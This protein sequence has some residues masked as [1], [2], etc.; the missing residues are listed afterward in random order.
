M[1]NRRFGFRRALVASACCSVITVAALTG[2]SG[3]VSGS[4]Q[5]ANGG[6]GA[7]LVVADVFVSDASPSLGGSTTLTA[8]VR[9]TGTADAATTTLRYYRSTDA[10]ISTSDIEVGM[11]VIAELSSGAR[12]DESVQ[13]TATPG[14][15]Y[16]G[17]CVDPVADEADDT[18]NCSDAVL[19][20]VGNAA[21]LQGRPDLLV[22]S[23]SASDGSPSAGARFTL[24]ASVRNV[25][26]G[27]STAT[28]L[29]YYQ[30][31]DAAISASDT[32]VGTADIAELS[33]SGST[34]ESAQFT[35][36]STPGAYYFGA[37]VDPV[38]DEADN[39]NNCSTS[40]RITVQEPDLVVGPPSVSNAGPAVGAKFALTATVRN[41][42]TG[43]AV[44]TTLRYYRSEDETIS[45]TDRE[46]DS[47]AVAGL[48]SSGSSSQSVDLAAPSTP[49]SY[50][51][52]A[53]VDPVADESDTTNNCSTAVSVTVQQ[54]VT[55]TQ[56]DPD[57]VVP[58]AS[59]SESAP[60]A[61]ARFRLS[62]TV[63]N[64]GNGDADATSMYFYRSTDT[65]ITDADTR[66]GTA[67]VVAL[68]T[69]GSNA[70]W[71]DLTAP[72]TP[73]TYYYGACAGAVSDETDTTN[74]CSAAVTVTVPQPPR[75]DLT[76]AQ[77]SVTDGSPATGAPFTLS[78]T[79]S[80]GGTGDSEATTLRYYRSTDATISATDTRV[81]AN[82]IAELA[83]AG[84]AGRSVD[85][86]APSTPGKY[87]YGACVDAVAGEADTTN[88][89]SPSVTV[90]ILQPDLVVV[91][92]T[93]NQSDPEAGAQFT[94]SVTVENDGE[95]DS[96]AATL[97]YYSSTDAA[98]TTSDTQ[99]GTDSVA[100]LAAAAT[101]RQSVDLTA[102]STP[103]T[104]Y[105]GACVDAVTDESDTTNNCSASVTVMVTEPE[106]QGL[107][108]EISVEDEEHYAPVGDT[109]D[110]SAEVL[111]EEGDE[112]TGATVTWS[113][114]DTTIA[115][116]DSSGVMT[117]V[118][119]GW[120]TLTAMATVTGS[121]TQSL[122]RSLSAA[123]SDT[124]VSGSV[125][126]HVVEPVARIEID[127][128]SLSFNSVNG[129]ETL[130]A[131]L[132]DGN[133][134]EI[135][136]TYWGWSS[137]NEEVATVDGNS[138]T[139]KISAF[140]HS[141]GEGSTTVTLRANGSATGTASVTVTLPTARVSVD[142][143]ALTFEAL[144]D[145]E[146][147]TVTVLDENGDEDENATFSY[148]GSFS[149]CCGVLGK[150]F[151]I[152]KVDD[153]LEITAGSPGS[154]RITIC[155]SSCF[156]L[157]DEEPE[158]ADAVLLVTIYQKPASL[159]VSPDAVSLAVDGTATLSAA[160]Q[161]ANGND[162][163]LAGGDQ[164]GLVVHWE[165][166]DSAVATV[167]GADATGTDNT[168]ATATVSGVAAGSATITG[169]WWGAVRVSGT[170][171][172]TVTE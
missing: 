127:P 36:P 22:A 105:Y 87:Y 53:C 32:E 108:V 20:T 18:N 74:N 81:G 168:G 1:I 99:V 129:W 146:T 119:T 116:V 125:R 15:Y 4:P 52:G 10:T 96:D 118:G 27:S 49:G 73:G 5:S 12:T 63:R 40:V 131:T 31:A 57:L 9:N 61:G 102:P 47:A 71:V 51:Y 26:G 59:V 148:F 123:N 120:V 23:P 38:A 147:V 128:D 45:T 170:A 165:T 77:P 67:G 76:V 60:A 145:T 68:A 85:L 104:H 117:A 41:D 48:T 35:A 138:F 46:E 62:A 171:T 65:T 92:P 11:T 100:G 55:D 122:R 24:S 42:G 130:T 3:A 126:M 6:D 164:G 14:A 88:N 137:A 56:G 91:S 135:R 115:T 107:S 30:S 133:D 93:V 156:R 16:Y 37:C 141:V 167:E 82:Q 163:G 28:T 134:N 58:V 13:L 84:S 110:L 29:R 98:I 139:S 124:T 113:S 158:I 144:G 154:G 75:P 172:V 157:A 136:P 43:S 159:T 79:V 25:G 152:T 160:I 109:V 132:Y 21:A 155:S 54:T 94:L 83:A 161:D 69:A 143:I 150:G 8:R 101:S 19:V 111:D 72:S 50:F 103:G 95:D 39:T 17:A 140:V 90:T 114:S 149:P 66:V 64:D 121:S 153:G 70:Q 89:C 34:T 33:A 166:S 7:D 162:I 112:I 44:A 78:A 80:N 86:T 2:C 169:G 142:P 106:Q 151:D 97:R